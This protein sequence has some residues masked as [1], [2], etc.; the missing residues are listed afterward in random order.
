[1]FP[2]WARAAD[3]SVALLQVEA[4]RSPYAK[5]VTA[6]VGELATRSEQFRTR[7]AAHDVTA[8]RRGTKRFHHHVVGD[9]SLRFEALDILSAGGLTPVGYSAEPG[10]ASQEALQLLASWSATEQQAQQLP[11]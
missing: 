7:W 2:D 3:D 4:A 1:M 6:L 9:L 11:G 10:S 5:A 8:H